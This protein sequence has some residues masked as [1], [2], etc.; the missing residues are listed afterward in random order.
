MPPRFVSRRHLLK[1]ARALASA[2]NSVGSE[3]TSWFAV[4]FE[5]LGRLYRLKLSEVEP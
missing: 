3:E 2:A 4:E 5:S 1:A